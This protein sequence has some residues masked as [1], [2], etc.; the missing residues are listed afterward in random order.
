MFELTTHQWKE[1]VRSVF[2][3]RN[4]ILNIILGFF[5]I[6]FLLYA[7]LIGFFADKI[8]IKLYEGSK[9]IDKFNGLLFYYFSVDLIIRFLS[10]SLPTLSIQPYL[11]LPIPKKKL[12]HYPLIKSGLSFF[13]LTAMLLLFPF[14]VKVI[15]TSQT[16]VYGM[17][18]VSTVL[19]LI[20]TNNFLTY[21]IKKYFL[22]KPMFVL[23]LLTG[24]GTLIW[25][26]VQGIVPM[27]LYFSD[28]FSVLTSMPF[29]ALIPITVAVLSYI[30][31]YTLLKKNS[32][33]EDSISKDVKNTGSFSFLN[34]YGEIG[35]LLSI[36]L[37]LILRNN[38]PKGFLYSSLFF[39]AY[40]L[41]FY[42][43]KNL[44]N[45]LVMSFTGVL[46]PAMFSLQHGQLF[47]SWESSFFDCFRSNRIRVLN[48]IKSKYIFHIAAITIG[49]IFTLPYMFIDYRIGWINLAFLCF[50]IGINSIVSIF[51]STYN[52][53]Y[54][55]L[56]RSIFMNY[57]GISSIQ[58]LIL[59]PAIGLPFSIY[60]I[61]DYLGIVNYYYWI[62]ASFGLIGIV[63]SGYL[64]KVLAGRFEKRKYKM[65]VGFKEK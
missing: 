65:S 48:Y 49:F 51:L 56:G 62:I 52:K 5:G 1:K 21:A 31:I 22:V 41:I 3:H 18:W 54:I 12:L 38:R 4:M 15:A 29:L 13:N 25:L 36:E 16:A 11:T 23:L 20:V 35:Q 64:L 19:S 53:S 43:N 60:F 44:D 33:L 26:E 37:K 24:L 14:F 6:L 61:C 10:Q 9:I 32:Y 30:L 55:D 45:H 17:V 58:F 47:F 27:S 7:L 63:W 40:G 8:I 57:Q 59:I 39:M 34:R 28:V 2:W 46:I 42:K 50:N